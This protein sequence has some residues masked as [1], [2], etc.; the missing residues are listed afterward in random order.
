MTCRFII[1]AFDV[2]IVLYPFL[3]AYGHFDLNHSIFLINDNCDKYILFDL[4][5]FNSSLFIDSDR[6]PQILLSCCPKYNNNICLFGI[7]F[8]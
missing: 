8:T 2:V 4:I 1:V 7:P 3:N 6:I 5:N